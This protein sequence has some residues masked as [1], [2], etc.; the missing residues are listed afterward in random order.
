MTTVIKTTESKMTDAIVDKR[1]VETQE[2]TTTDTTDQ[3]ID[4]TIE[5]VTSVEATEGKTGK[6]VQTL[7]SRNRS[8]K[9]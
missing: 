2:V 4:V 8:K 3:S 6:V 5:A 1:T 7:G 9:R